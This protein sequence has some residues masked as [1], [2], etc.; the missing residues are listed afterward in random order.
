MPIPS[1]YRKGESD[2]DF[3]SISKLYDAS[4]DYPDDAVGEFVAFLEDSARWD[5]L[6]LVVISDLGQALG[7]GGLYG[8]GPELT[9]VPM[10]VR[11]SDENPW[12]R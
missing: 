6:V 5:D 8:V 10:I 7:E 11:T 4:V 9:T 3:E 12:S 1:Q 2:A